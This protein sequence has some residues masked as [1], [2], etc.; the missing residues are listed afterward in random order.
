I[1]LAPPNSGSFSV[2]VVLP[3]SGWLMIAKVRRRRTSARACSLAVVTGGRMAFQPGKT[4]RV[5]SRRSGLEQHRA[6]VRLGLAARGAIPR[7]TSLGLSAEG[8][9]AETCSTSST[10]AFRLRAFDE[11]PGARSREGLRHG[12]LAR[13]E[14]LHVLGLAP[15]VALLADAARSGQMARHH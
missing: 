1:G 7:T 15:V 14:Q 2:R 8:F 11:N 12:L 5:G 13:P 3:A 10:A 4:I 6:P 9:V